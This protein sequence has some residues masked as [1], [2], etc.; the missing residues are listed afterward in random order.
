MPD[1]YAENEEISRRLGSRDVGLEIAQIDR[2]HELKAFIDFPWSVYA[3]DPNWVPPLKSSVRFLLD[4]D[5]HPFWGFSDRV[6][7][8]AM[9]DG[10]PVGRIAGI[11]DR[12]HNRYHQEGMGSWGFFEC[13]NDKE[14]A[15][16][17]FNRVEEWVR[18]QGM[19]FLR[20]PLN[21]SMNYEVGLLTEGFEHRATF[22]MPYNYPYYCDLVESAGFRKEKDLLSFLVDN[23]WRPP[24][25]IERL[26]RRLKSN[27]AAYVRRGDRRRLNEDLRLIK[28][29]YD[30][31][32]A[33]N[34]GFVPMTEKEFGFMCDELKRI[35][36]D[37]LIF[38]VYVGDRPVGAA[39]IVP[40]INP[41]LKR[42][43]GKIGLS[44]L[45]KVLL[46]KREI[47]GTRG[48]LFGIKEGYRQ[49]GL[50]FVA[51]DYLFDTMRKKGNYDYL[52]LGWNL[53]DNEDINQLE[54][55]GGARL[56]KRYRIYRKDFPDR[57]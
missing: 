3:G 18:E 28:K 34:W 48:L 46:Y 56:F 20:G 30:E 17:L 16:A 25:W 8:L 19:T 27:G 52:E 47:R 4:R 36:D 45:I 40:D 2:P 39:V 54:S 14:V 50:P 38:F 5:R 44:G 23:K 13:F 57:W 32:W 51:L 29:I 7:F 24:E 9:R 15:H 31:C 11:V 21:P 37:D 42:L 43:N 26:I 10:R 35:A 33:G 6:L 55:E 1:S 49:T 22:M 41:L 53:E 12:N